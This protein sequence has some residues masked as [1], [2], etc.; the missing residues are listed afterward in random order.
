[1]KKIPTIGSVRKETIRINWAAYPHYNAPE[2]FAPFILDGRHLY[3][4]NAFENA[5]SSMETSAVA[6][7]NVVRLILSRHIGKTIVHSSKS[8]DSSHAEEGIHLDL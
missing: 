1:M 7:E 8:S 5:A 6:A 3:Y 2:V 4:I